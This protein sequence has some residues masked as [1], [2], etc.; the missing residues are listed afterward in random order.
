VELLVAIAILAL[1]LAIL[2]PAVQQAREASRRTECQSHLRQ[3]GIAVQNY[4]STHRMLP[5]GASNQYSLHVF[6]LPHL[7]ELPLYDRVDF[8]VAPTVP[9]NETLWASSVAVYHCPSDPL[10]DSR[11]D[12][13][14][15]AT[16][17]AGNFGSGVQRYGYNGMFR[18][19]AEMLM[20]GR[21]GP[22]RVR[23]VTDGLSNTTAVSEVL[24][25][26]GSPLRFRTIL[27][28]TPP[29]SGADQLD[30]F[31]AA[32]ASLPPLLDSANVWSRGR[33]WVQGDLDCT[34]YNHVL[35]PNR[36][37]C[38][39]RSVEDGAFTAASVHPGGVNVLYGDGRVSFVA[40]VVDR[41]VWR[42]I[43]S[44][45]GSEAIALP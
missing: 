11:P 18:Y 17:Y 1:L 7:G 21:G 38:C 27:S 15:Y 41:H 25:S 6:L 5:P 36:N 10:A 23:D 24:V 29:L 12:G 4:E 13:A 33:P 14:P 3:I 39:N 37:S 43:G 31:A 30:A 19:L 22:V 16:N 2:L 35:P 44:R 9:A 42:S 26:D 20:F 28:V 32:C 40:D 8:S 34:F 45:D